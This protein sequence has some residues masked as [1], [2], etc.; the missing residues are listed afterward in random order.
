[1]GNASGVGKGSALEG[2]LGA[3][4]GHWVDANG[5]AGREQAGSE[6]DEGADDRDEHEDER[7]ADGRVGSEFRE[8]QCGGEGADEAESEARRDQGDALAEGLDE[9]L[10]R[11]GAEGGADAE[12]GER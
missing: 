7:V 9:D 6:R 5:A 11:A 1:M 4:G 8:E 12:G 3:E 10:A 2:L